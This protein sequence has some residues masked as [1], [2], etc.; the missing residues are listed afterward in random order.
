MEQ[1]KIDMFIMANQK[2]F[3]AEKVLYIKEKLKSMD[4]DKLALVST[5]EFK[6]PIV[7][8][9]VSVLLGG[10]G[11]DRFMLGEIG[12]G[13]AKLL[14]AAGCGIWA[15]IDWFIISK[16]TKEKNFASLMMML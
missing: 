15:I 8:T 1:Q 14:T 12:A 2:Y 7:L 13:V 6:D 9:I 5:M 10:I 4:E 16:R 3:P 11:V